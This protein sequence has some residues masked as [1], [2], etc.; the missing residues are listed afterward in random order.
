M[1]HA[2]PSPFHLLFTIIMLENEQPTPYSLQTWN[3]QHSIT[4]IMKKNYISYFQ[5]KSLKNKIKSITFWIYN[6]KILLMQ[7]YIVAHNWWIR[8]LNFQSYREQQEKR[9]TIVNWGPWLTFLIREDVS[10]LGPLCSFVLHVQD[11][12]LDF[13][14]LQVLIGLSCC[15]ASLRGVSRV[16]HWLSTSPSVTSIWRQIFKKSWWWLRLKRGKENKQRK[17]TYCALSVWPLSF[18]KK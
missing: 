15:H 7:I 9:V 10:N 11:I 16:T 4:I 13:I 8:E 12:S 1:Y 5:C 17:I 2:F 6:Q 18:F 3:L 14:V